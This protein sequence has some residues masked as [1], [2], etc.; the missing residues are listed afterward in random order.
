MTVQST[1]NKIQHIS[2]ADQTDF[3]YDFVVLQEKDL[4]V[5]I[6]NVRYLGSYT[7]EG[8]G[9]D[10][11]G[12]VILSQPQ[13]EG[14][15]VV[16]YR[17]MEPTQEVDYKKYD[18]FPAETH[19]GAL[20]KLTLLVQQV[21]EWG[22]G[23]IRFP[24][25]EVFGPNSILPPVDER[26][27]KFLFFDT[28][29]GVGV[30]EGTAIGGEGVKSIGVANNSLN[31]IAVDNSFQEVPLIE[32][33][34]PNEP[35]R[36]VALDAIGKIPVEVL[37]GIQFEALDVTA[38]A[39]DMLIA[40]NVIPERPAVGTRT[41]NQPLSLIQL[42]AG[43]TIPP[44][45]INIS[46]LRNL[47]IFRGD[48]LC[49]KPGDNP[50]ECIVPDHR[51]PSERFPEAEDS[52]QGG[53]FFIITIE[54]PEVDGSINLFTEAFQTVY[55]PILVEK[56][57]GCIYF[58]E[59]RNEFNDLIFSE[60]WYYVKDMIQQSSAEFVAYDPTGNL[61]ILPADINVDLALN[62]LDLNALDKQVGGVVGGPISL[63]TIPTLD[64]HLTNKLYVDNANTVQD[65]A[66]SDLVDR[67][68]LNEA[69]IATNAADILT[70]IGS[71]DYAT[72][73][74]GGVV[75]IRVA[76]NDAFFSTTVNNP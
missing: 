49:D 69:D 38:Q 21:G 60:G 39:V 63:A 72:E 22:V 57:D 33:R 66:I 29:G 16:L 62:R 36:L 19:E 42:S 25:V 14:A 52:F 54:A 3:V 18:S 17:A 41:P 59:L 71:T 4:L 1:K 34:T 47:G 24:L 28:D 32:I 40:D 61:I 51:N 55:A 37:P 50:G 5:A 56:G 30:S 48:N 43:G 68:T 27:L 23:A 53:D 76:I 70:K 8:V 9:D 58:E 26:A 20:D 44:D 65:T 73:T 7:V 74:V 75:K 35:N 45:L 12:T 31:Y 64:A 2:L 46:G 13:E 11:G 67:V 15:V 6:D 10:F